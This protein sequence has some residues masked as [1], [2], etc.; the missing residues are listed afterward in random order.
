METS[1]IKV[2]TPYGYKVHYQ[3]DWIMFTRSQRLSAKMGMNFSYLEY[4]E[5]I[6]IEKL[7]F[8]ITDRF[9][10][11]DHL[12][13]DILMTVKPSNHGLSKTKLLMDN[14]AGAKKRVTEGR[15]EFVNFQNEET[16]NGCLQRLAEA[17]QETIPS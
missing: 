6:G 13:A 10:N 5:T 11:S 2:L 16:K 9:L 1:F 15:N 12:S 4:F 7:V 17:I 3:P 8:K 14:F